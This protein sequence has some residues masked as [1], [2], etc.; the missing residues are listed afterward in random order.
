[1]LLIFLFAQV[2]TNPVNLCVWLSGF[3]FG[4]LCFDL[5]FDYEV[6]LVKLDSRR[7]RPIFSGSLSN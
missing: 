5:V 1:M 2:F 7:V 4:V 6:V 3:G